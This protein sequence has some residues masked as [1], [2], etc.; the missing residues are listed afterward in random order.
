MTAI[1][2]SC[3]GRKP[4]TAAYSRSRR[5]RIPTGAI[6]ASRPRI[7]KVL[8]LTDQM[9]IAVVFLAILLTVDVARI[10]QRL[11]QRQRD[12]R[13]IKARLRSYFH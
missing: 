6:L 8:T 13:L 1:L 12:Q 11:L 2:W 9:H 3:H 4:A 10:Y 5:S 7:S